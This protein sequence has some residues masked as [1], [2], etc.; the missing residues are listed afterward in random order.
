MKKEYHKNPIVYITFIYFICYIFRSIEYMLIRTDQSTLGEAFIHKLIGIAIL[1]IGLKYLSIRAYEIGFKPKEALK[2]IIYGLFLGTSVY[3][4]AYAV[5]FLILAMSDKTPSVLLFVSSYS[6]DGNF[7]NQTGLVFF[8]IC[9]IGNLINVV[10]EEGIFRGLFLKLAEKKYSFLV[11]VLISSVLFG[12][13][14]IA[15]P[16]RSFLDGE[17]SFEGTVMMILMLVVTTG[18]TGAKFCLLTKISG[19]LWLAMTDHFVNNTTNNM[20]HISTNQGIDELQIVRITIAQTTSFLIVLLIFL[21]GK[22]YKKA[23]STI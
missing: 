3:I 17:R 5:E 9:I 19:S 23:H 6:I 14:H 8:V 7:G 12:F 13:W 4:L 2:N 18:I 10:M 16:L 22:Y 20:L 21:K 1:I 15:A 11:A